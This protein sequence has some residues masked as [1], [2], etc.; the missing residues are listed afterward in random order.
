MGEDP[1]FAR[2]AEKLLFIGLCALLAFATLA[3]GTYDPWSKAILEGGATCLLALW[4]VITITRSKISVQWTPL[5]GPITL[6]GTVIFVQMVFGLSARLQST[7]D[8]V[9][10]YCAYAML[11]FI[12]N[13]VF[14]NERNQMRF[15][16]IFS[17]LGFAIAMFAIVQSLT[18]H[19]VIY[20]YRHPRQ[21]SSVFGPYFNRNHYAGWM[22]MVWPMAMVL[23]LSSGQR[24]GVRIVSGFAAVVMGFSILLCSSRTGSVTFMTQLLFIGVLSLAQKK[25][26]QLRWVF[27]GI[28]LATAIFLFW[29][30]FNSVWD[31]FSPVHVNTELTEGRL[32][33]TKDTLQMGAM[34]PLLGWG[35]GTFP[36]VYPE[37]RSFYTNMFVNQ[38]HNDYAQIWA[39]T[40]AIGSLAMLWFV[41]ILL[42]SGVWG[43]RRGTVWKATTNARLAAFTGCVGILIHSFADFNL[44][45]AANAAMFY[46]L[47]ALA[48]MPHGADPDNV[49]EM[50][51]IR[52]QTDEIAML[53]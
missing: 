21:E 30:G 7:Q 34:K 18:S 13:V 16:K 14:Q 25:S 4:C 15:L 8:E 24:T 28:F 43:V 52:A 50:P 45:I 5:M 33:I 11:F 39:E 2:K 27:A 20:W 22:E 35:L 9:I 26:K 17:A 23:A 1:G 29:F 6:F 48:T 10:L 47:C 44:H 53:T 32:A 41:L 37:Y 3:Y 40:G 46:V 19:G 51:I 12:A 42:S 36:Y 31:R 38:A 49:R